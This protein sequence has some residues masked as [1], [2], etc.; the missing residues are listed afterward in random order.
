VD[1][2]K[3][4]IDEL[5]DMLHAEKQILNALP[6]MTQVTTS[7]ALRRALEEE[8]QETKAQTMRIEEVF[9][10]ISKPARPKA[11]PGMQGILAEGLELVREHGKPATSAQAKGK[12]A[13]KRTH[14]GRSQAQANRATGSGD[15]DTSAVEAGLIACMQKAIHYRMASHG[16]LAAWA[17]ALDQPAAERLLRENL[18]ADEDI[19][20]ELSDVAAR[21]INPRAAGS[22]R[23][24]RGATA[25]TRSSERRGQEREPGTMARNAQ[26]D[27]DERGFG[28]DRDDDRERDR[29]SGYAAEGRDPY[30]SRGGRSERE[31]DDYGRTGREGRGSERYPDE[32][33]WAGVRGSGA[34]DDRE[35]DSPRG[36]EDENR[37]RT[38]QRGER[39]RLGS[40]VEEGRGRSAGRSS[41]SE[42]EDD[43]DRRFGSET[44]W[45]TSESDQR[46]SGGRSSWDDRDEESG[47]QSGTANRGRSRH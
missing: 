7:D 46:Q 6:K 16:T 37:G 41:R 4:F 2:N 30:A 19:D 22:E 26:R 12:A 5:G 31:R 45:R 8:L 3:I 10:T 23:T 38:S 42:Y 21:L 27:R 39:A 9:R 29:W 32:R 20:R 35:F 40:Q 24:R 25:Q 28:R 36:W 11:C 1:L 17:E 13:K 18:M 15:R 44:A 14:N 34:D 43:R 33:R 47:R